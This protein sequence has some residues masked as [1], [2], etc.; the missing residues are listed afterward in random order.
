M[1]HLAR[2]VLW[3]TVDRPVALEAEA[4]DL[5]RSLLLRL[6][7]PGSAKGSSAI[8]SGL[9]CGGRQR[10]KPSSIGRTMGRWRELSAGNWRDFFV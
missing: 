9:G 3:Q 7:R 5:R 6:L 4:A 2:S 10:V 8:E 1:C